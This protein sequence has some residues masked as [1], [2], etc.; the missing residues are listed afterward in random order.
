[1]KNSVISQ[2]R[3]CLFF[4]YFVGAHDIP[5]IYFFTP[6]IG[7]RP[8][9]TTVNVSSRIFFH[10]RNLALNTLSKIRLLLSPS[11]LL[12][13]ARIKRTYLK[14]AAFSLVLDAFR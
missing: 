1:M 12:L 6:R 4:F 10:S 3:S 5:C 11:S 8:S 7:K 14:S 9:C 2:L 13:Y